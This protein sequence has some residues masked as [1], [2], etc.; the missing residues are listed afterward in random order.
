M[1][2]LVRMPV[3]KVTQ[4]AVDAA[5]YCDAAADAAAGGGDADVAGDACDG[6]AVIGNVNRV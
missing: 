6:D 5:A 4:R 2:M 3:I 1:R